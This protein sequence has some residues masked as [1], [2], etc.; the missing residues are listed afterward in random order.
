MIRS[1]ARRG[2]RT[3]PLEMTSLAD[4]P[5]EERAAA[6]ARAS[7]RVR[8]LEAMRDPSDAHV[9]WVRSL[10]EELRERL[11]ALT[12]R[13]QD[14]RDALDAG[15]DVDL[16]MQMFRHGALD[17]EE[18]TVVV[19]VVFGRLR[20]CCAPVQDEAV[21]HAHEHLL[22]TDDVPTRLAV[23]LEVAHRVLDDIDD[24]TRRAA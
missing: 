4:L 5:A 18:S 7:M 3:G 12:P 24:L 8:V 2:F 20:T 11:R 9:G 14:L 16:L 23:L 15:F 17:R 22:R 21:A 10:C 1:R 13:R 6:I 19:D